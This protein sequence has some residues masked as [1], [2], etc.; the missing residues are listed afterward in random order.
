MKC[1]IL[2]L[3]LLVLTACNEAEMK[4]ETP[5][6]MLIGGGSYCLQPT[7]D[8]PSF[9]VQQKI[10]ANF[11]GRRETMIAT[12]ENDEAGL[13]FV[14][15][16]PFGQTLLQV[17]YDNR[18]MSAATLPD[19]RLS[20]ALLVALLQIALWPTDSVRSGLEAPLVLEEKPGQRRILRHSETTLVI[21]YSGDHPPYRRLHLSIPDADLELDIETL[22]DFG[23]EP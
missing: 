3:L 15:L 22:A 11:R 13:R 2:A 23:N 10:E 18:E 20:P 9:E 7:S 5:C 21:D 14:G 4:T 1:S 19:R 6:A 8:L 12:I 16:T 17:G